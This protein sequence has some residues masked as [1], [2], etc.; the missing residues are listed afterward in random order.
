MRLAVVILVFVAACVGL[1]LAGNPYALRLATTGLMYA[2]LALSWNVIGG[3]CGYPSFATA[4]F[5]GVG[6]YTGAIVQNAGLP[7]WLA[8][9]AAPLVSAA[10]AATIGSAI[11]RLHGHYFAVGSLVVPEVLREIVNSAAGLTGGGMGLNIPVLRFSIQQQGSLFLAAMGIV[12]VAA[13]VLTVQIDRGRLGVAFRCIEQ[14]ESAAVMIGV[15][16]TL[17]KVI[18]FTLSGLVA[19]AVGGVYANWINYIDPSDAFDVLIS[20]KPIVMV[21][22]GGA[23]TVYGPL[24]GAGL[25]VLL[26]EIVWRNFLT[27]HTG[28][29]GL[30]IVLLILFLPQGAARLSPLTLMRILKPRRMCAE[31]QS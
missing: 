1:S 20:V 17:Y 24:L 31:G 14:N 22:L 4:A 3:Y 18:A 5:F 30:I 28:I 15:N 9:L 7:V 25:F 13:L 19:G 11:L 8:W 27:I 6:A 23:G 26:E 21:M 10:L 29:L 12:T 16:A 2:S